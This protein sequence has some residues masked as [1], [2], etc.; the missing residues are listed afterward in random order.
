MVKLM[1]CLVRRADVDEAEFHRYWRDEHAPL[2]A[3]HAEV[4]GLRR[5]VQAHAVHPHLN[6]ALAATRGAPASYDGVAELWVDSVAT[7]RMHA[8]AHPGRGGG[9]LP[10][11]FWTTNGVSSTT[12]A[13]PSS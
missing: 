12:P 8:A 6:A 13:H 4:L 10:G 9:Q 3:T 11:S 7:R 5:Y 2:V 1:F